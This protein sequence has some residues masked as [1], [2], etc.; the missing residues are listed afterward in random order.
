MVKLIW[1]S[2]ASCTFCNLFKAHLKETGAEH[3]EYSVD[4]PEGRE[5]AEQYNV[6]S[7]P[8]LFFV[9]DDIIVDVQVGFDA[10]GRNI[11]DTM[12]ELEAR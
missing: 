7:F 2:M 1:F 8:T 5:K 11:I 3:T 6:N 12:K 4:T 9:K 10:K